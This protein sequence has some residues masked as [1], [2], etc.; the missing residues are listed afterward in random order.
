M[1]RPGLIEKLNLDC[2]LI[3]FDMEKESNSN[4]IIKME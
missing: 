2:L 4:I 3:E 1:L